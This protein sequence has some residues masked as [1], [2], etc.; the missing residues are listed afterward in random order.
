MRRSVTDTLGGWDDVRVSA[1]MEMIWRV[2]A[3]YGDAAVRRILPDIPMA[4]ALDDA[5]S[6]TRKSDTHVRSTYGG[7]R[8]YYREIC[9][10]WHRQAPEGLSDDQRAAKWGMLPAAIKADGSGQHPIDISITADCSDPTVL[11]DI[12]Q[13]VDNQPEL[14]F[15]I[16]HVPDPAFQ[17]RHCGYAIEFPDTFFDLLTR[18]NV[19]IADTPDA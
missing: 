19:T 5:G 6:L 18:G 1:D 13:R 7:L 15:G 10:Y 14:Q 4:F 3:A 12:A 16:S 17:T 11:S 9:R 2:Q 8:H